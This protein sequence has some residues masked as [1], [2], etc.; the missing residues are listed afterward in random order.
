[1]AICW[2]GGYEAAI[3]IAITVLIIASL[4]AINQYQ[5]RADTGGGPE[6]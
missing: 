6:Q 3:F 5:S 4:V 2:P 1:M